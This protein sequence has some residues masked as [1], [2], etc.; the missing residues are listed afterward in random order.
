M[1]SAF[2]F[3]ISPGAGPDIGGETEPAGDAL[4]RI[5]EFN[6]QQQAASWLVLLDCADLIATHMTDLWSAIDGNGAGYAALSQARKDL[7]DWLGTATIA[8]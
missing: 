2:K 3:A 4:T 8:G 1:R 6:L 7:Y 5:R